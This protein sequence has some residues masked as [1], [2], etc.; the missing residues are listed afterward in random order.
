MPRRPRFCPAG[1]PVHV[2]QR[3]NN[4]QVI[5]TCESDLAAYS[6]WL[7]DGAVR[8]GVSVHGWVFMTNHVHLLATPDDNNSVSRLMQFLGRLYVRRF[9]Y[10]YQRSGTLFEGRFRSCVVQDD[11]YLLRCLRYIELNP[12]RAGM[13]ADPGDY[14]WSSFRAHAFGVRPRLWSPH[15]TYLGIGPDERQRGQ[16]WRELVGKALGVDVLAKIR[17]CANTGIVLGTEAFQVEVDRRRK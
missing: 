3:G 4:R 7:A 6:N 12:V 11:Q 2:I 1:L 5:F 10:T 15:D 14:V 9:N 17:H 16:A 13:V 8:Y